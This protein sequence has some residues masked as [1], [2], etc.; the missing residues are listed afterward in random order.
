M[1]DLVGNPKDRFTDVAAHMSL[2]Q[3]S[4]SFQQYCES[5]VPN[6]VSISD[7]VTTQTL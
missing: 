6:E 1:P 3:Y 2:L 5:V 4:S 7:A